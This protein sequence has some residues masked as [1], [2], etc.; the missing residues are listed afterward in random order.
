MLNWLNSL[1]KDFTFNIKEFLKVL[2]I[3]LKNQI[4][5]CVSGNS[6]RVTT[7]TTLKEVLNSKKFSSGVILFSEDIEKMISYKNIN[8]DKESLDFHLGCIKTISEENN[9]EISYF[10]AIFLAGLNFFRE[11][12]APIIIIDNSFDFIKE[13]EYDHY[14]F[15][16]YN[17]EYS[18]NKINPKDIYLYKSE[19]CSFSYNN[20]DY[21]ALNYGSFSAYPYLLAL[22]FL[23]DFY[24]EIKEKKIRKVIND[25][26]PLLISERVNKNPRVILHLAFDQNDYNYYLDELKKITE[27][28]IVTISNN[29]S[30]NPNYLIIDENEVKDII[31]KENIDSIILII[32]DK[33]FVKDIRSFFRN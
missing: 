3:D 6:F 26:D 21:D 8:I 32:G 25:Q 12:K 17:D 16:G 23:V 10:E 4:K 24:P 14:L 1:K 30:F 28:N 7:I 9:L 18:Y 27:R 22:S 15:N 20:L 33:V 5:I 29:K 31:N 13:I 11:Q 19:L 2:E